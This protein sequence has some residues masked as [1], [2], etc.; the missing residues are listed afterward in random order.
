MVAEE[1]FA[2]SFLETLLEEEKGVIGGITKNQSHLA[3]IRRVFKRFV[4]VGV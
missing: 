1:N 4:E 3:S 2:Y